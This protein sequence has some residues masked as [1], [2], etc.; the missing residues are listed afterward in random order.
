MMLRMTT[1]RAT[2]I[3]TAFL[4]FCFLLLSSSLPAAGEERSLLWEKLL[5]GDHFVMIRHALAPGIGDPASF[6]VDK[7][8]TQRNLSQQ[9]REQARAIGELFRKNNI[10]KAQVYSSQWCRCL[11]TA[12][13]LDLGDVKELPILNSFFQSFEDEGPQTEALTQWLQKQDLT[14]P[15]ILVTHQVNITA[16]TDIYPSSGEIVVVQ[17]KNNGLF[18]P[19]GKISTN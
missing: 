15:V 13:L 10:A 14:P 8:G 6:S 7:C 16:F 12:R 3:L 5:S 1:V 11:D 9:G 2:N 19:V 4:L 18:V 17:R